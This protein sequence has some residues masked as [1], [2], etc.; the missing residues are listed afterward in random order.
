MTRDE[1]IQAA[2][3]LRRTM[4]FQEVADILGVSRSTAH[5][6]LDSGFP[7]KDKAYKDR[8][9][10][11]IQARDRAYG[12]ANRGT[13]LRCSGPMGIGRPHDGVCQSCVSTVRHERC[14]QI[15]AWWAEGLSWADIA[16]EL[17]WTMGH[18]SV[19]MDRMRAAGYDLPYRYRVGRRAGRKHERAT[20]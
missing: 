4:T 15:V 17:G 5:R 9:R 12:R 18:M 8:H 1:K 6:L 11:Q 16:A 2:W 14:L 20:A 19:E 7:T 10:E 3:W 13:C